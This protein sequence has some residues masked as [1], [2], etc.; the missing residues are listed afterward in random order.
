M[1]A[2]WYAALRNP[3]ALRS[4]WGVAPSLVGARMAELHL[5][6]HGLRLVFDP[7]L[8]P[9][10]VARRWP[11]GANRVQ[12][13]I[14]VF[15]VERLHCQGTPIGGCERFDIER[16]GQHVVIHVETR[17]A[18]LRCLGVEARVVSLT[19]YVDTAA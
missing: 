15:G 4:T 9:E 2:D 6:H 19:G 3:E 5:D 13:T 14:D 7:P 1:T 10:R 18:R 17:T 16:E 8:P 11:P 12:V